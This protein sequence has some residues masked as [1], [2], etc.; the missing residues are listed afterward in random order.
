MRMPRLEQLWTVEQVLALPSDGNRYEVID[1]E[2]FVTP[3]PSLNHQSAAF[4]LCRLLQ[5]YLQRERVGHAYVAPAD[6]TF[7]PRRLVQPDVFAVPLVN[8]RRPRRFEDAGKLLL[9]AEIL[10]PSTARADR[11]RKRDMFRDE[12]VPEYWVVDLD[13]RAIERSTPRD[14]RVELLADRIEWRP[15]GAETT[16]EVDLA[17]YFARVL[18]D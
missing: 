8:G 4:E 17:D 14:P 15:A 3:A 16:L 1:G 12:G 7:S 2:L 6:V 11:I 5:E 9:T 10:S 18:D 13:A